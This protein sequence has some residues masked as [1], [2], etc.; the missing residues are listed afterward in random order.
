MQ[1]EN[2]FDLDYLE[3]VK[4]TSNEFDS[5]MQEYDSETHVSQEEISENTETKDVMEETIKD[6]KKLEA[7]INDMVIRQFELW[8][9]KFPTG[10]MKRRLKREITY[11]F[12]K[13]KFPK[14]MKYPKHKY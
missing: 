5:L 13:G 12:S 8:G 11:E 9:C 14:L 6:A 4:E 3:K 7:F 2:N 1:N 10:K